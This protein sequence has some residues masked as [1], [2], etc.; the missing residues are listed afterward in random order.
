MQLLTDDPRIKQ[1]EENRA[2]ISEMIR[3]FGAKEI[4]PFKMEWDESQEFPRALFHKLGKLGLMG[5]TAGAARDAGGKV[6]G[7][8]PDLFR[9]NN[10]PIHIK[11]DSFN[12]VQYGN[13]RF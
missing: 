5:A 6:F 3:D 1:E 13:Q 11:N 2:M 4:E 8:I 10:H 12:H 9:I 7:V